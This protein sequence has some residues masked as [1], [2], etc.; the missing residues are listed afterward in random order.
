VQAL[1]AAWHP[2][3]FVCT[4]CGQPIG[5]AKF[6]VYQGAPYHVECYQERFSPRCVYC[7]K[8][9]ISEYFVDHWGQQYCKEHQKQYPT[10]N[11]CGRL[12]PSEQAEH[13]TEVVRCPICRSSAVETAIEA[14]PLFLQAIHWVNGQGLM[15]NNLPLSLELCD[16]EKL[17]RHL[18]SHNLAHALG[19]TTSRSY[20]QNGQVTHV[21]V[22]GVAVLQGLPATL[23]QGVTVH[24]LGHVW[25]IVHGIR[26]LPA[27][28][29]EGFC[30]LLSYRYYDHLHTAES[31]FQSTNIEKNPDHTYGDGFRRIHT[32]S[33]ALTFPRLIGIL[34]TTK[35]LPAK[36]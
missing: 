12:V 22:S 33:D 18:H 32:L 2:E 16:R 26:D 3:H 27:W 30:E 14:K 36:P 28:A 25:L 5:K 20:T 24:E 34:R 1:G 11:Y 9:L 29:E 17:A 4:G 10:C 7:G 31:T 8:P 35:R 13:G 23:F 21:E 19:A 6:Q 15:Y